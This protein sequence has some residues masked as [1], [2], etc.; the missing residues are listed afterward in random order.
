MFLEN[1]RYYKL[2]TVDAKA[3]DGRGVK[4]VTLRILPC[5][6]GEGY[7]VTQYDRLDILA[8]RSYKDATS[9]WH[10][11]DANTELEANDLTREAG[12][13]IVIPDK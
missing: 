4:A 2:K 9:S 6:T 10:I 12:R 11:A 7:V 8:H 13:K 5:E 3:R 1:S